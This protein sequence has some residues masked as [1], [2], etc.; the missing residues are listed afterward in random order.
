MTN[1]QAEFGIN[2]ERIFSRYVRRLVFNRNQGFPAC[3]RLVVSEANIF[4][5]RANIFSPRAKKR[6][7]LE[8]FPTSLALWHCWQ[9]ASRRA[10]FSTLYNNNTINFKFSTLPLPH[11]HWF[12]LDNAVVS[13]FVELT[14]T[15]F[16]NSTNIT[17]QKLRRHLPF[18]LIALRLSI[19]L[20]EWH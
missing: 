10:I 3:N 4:P 14:N 7:F 15:V 20:K 18:I 9:N 11:C 5:S 6:V 2:Q 12:N 8:H 1:L 17:L 16:L 13:I 19:L